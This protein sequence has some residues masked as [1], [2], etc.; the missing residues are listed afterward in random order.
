MGRSIAQMPGVARDRRAAGFT[1]AHL[2]TVDQSLWFLL[3]AQLRAVRDA[4]GTAIG[5]SAPGPW[6]EQ[7]EGE[8]IRHIPLA[9]ST[10]SADAVADL[11]AARELWQLLR[12]ERVD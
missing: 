1:V 5:I 4:G 7:L 2:T 11:R 8:G 12:R 10:R 3:L 9:S 6:V